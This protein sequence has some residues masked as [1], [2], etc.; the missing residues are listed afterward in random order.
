MLEPARAARGEALDDLTGRPEPVA[1]E[2]LRAGRAPGAQ[3][4][5]PDDASRYLT[6]MPR[7]ARG[8]GDCD[9]DGDRGRARET[10]PEQP[11]RHDDEEVL[12]RR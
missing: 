10:S 11:E 4:G 5:R 8:G 9:G 6:E 7:L 2:L 12:F 3:A 1:P